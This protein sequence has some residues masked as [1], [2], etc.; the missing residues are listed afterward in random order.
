M[1]SFLRSTINRINQD[2]PPLFEV[3]I[4][5]GVIVI[6]WAEFN[7]NHLNSESDAARRTLHSQILNERESFSNKLGLLVQ[8]ATNW[9][10]N[11]ETWQQ[12]YQELD[13][14]TDQRRQLL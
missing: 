3:S 12:R 11:A 8:Q 14:E 2:G 9:Q 4:L 1:K 7:L 6:G 5:L 13:K 10:Q